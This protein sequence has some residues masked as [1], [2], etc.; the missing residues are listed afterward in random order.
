VE[1]PVLLEIPRGTSAPTLGG[2]ATL[3]STL[4]CTPG[5][6]A[7]DLLES[8]LYRAPQTTS[9]SWSLNGA[10]LAGA[11]AGT[12]AASA[13]GTYAC[14]ET[15]TNGS[16]S[17][18]HTSNPVSV[19]AAATPTVP[20]AA[21]P[22]APT[23]RLTKVKLDKKNGTA[24]LL[25]GVSG[26]GALTLTGKG[27]AKAKGS[28]KGAGVVKL[29][30]RAKG[31]TKKMLAETGKKKVK[32]KIVFAPGGGGAPVSATRSIVLKMQVSQP[33]SR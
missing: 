27:L 21:N 25:A 16:G 1:G 14:T 28:S 9:Y 6:W 23:I 30:V 19:A 24:V 31:K 4:T 8:F 11:T 32:A 29:T 3:G 20:T 10:P 13:A 26:P 17:S 22:V 2:S 33:P 15:A 5:S 7:G 18:S 12:L